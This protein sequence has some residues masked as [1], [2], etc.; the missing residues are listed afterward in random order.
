MKDET[1]YRL[2]KDV[3]FFLP[4]ELWQKFNLQSH[5]YP[6]GYTAY[7]II[8]NVI[9]TTLCGVGRS[10]NTVISHYRSA[11]VFTSENKSIYG[12]CMV[13]QTKFISYSIT[14]Y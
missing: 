12:R 10:I 11:S 14:T 13:V 2:E 4:S 5:V 9:L 7:V 6:S 8:K 1:Y 3:P